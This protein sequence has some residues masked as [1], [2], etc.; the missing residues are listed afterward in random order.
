MQN[1]CT[2]MWQWPRGSRAQSRESWCT[3]ELGLL[4]EV[5][6]V[7]PISVV[8]NERSYGLSYLELACSSNSWDKSLARCLG[9]NARH[10]HHISLRNPDS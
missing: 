10:C 6:E 8:G 3:K 7:Q 1:V 2:C 4:W 5:S 9:C